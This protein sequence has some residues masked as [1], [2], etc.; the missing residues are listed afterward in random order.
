MCCSGSGGSARSRVLAAL[1]CSA[2]GS[3]WRGPRWMTTTEAMLPVARDV[4][5][6][7]VAVD[8][9][10]CV[11]ALRIAIGSCSSPSASIR[12]R[13]GI[14]LGRLRRRNPAGCQR[15]S[16]WRVGR[17]CVA[18]F[19]CGR[20]SRVARLARGMT[21]EPRSPRQ[22][23][24]VENRRCSALSDCWAQILRRSR[25]TR[26]PSRA[27]LWRCRPAGW[28]APPAT[29]RRPLRGELPGRLPVASTSPIEAPV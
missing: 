17:A 4:S 12:A 8:T 24:S 15:R 14:P 18:P 2:R 28:R 1:P 21:L 11:C 22:S 5:I 13:C 9:S 20:R 26:P 6:T 10:S 19:V 23:S 27:P 25:V 7:R 29:A 16:L 3:M